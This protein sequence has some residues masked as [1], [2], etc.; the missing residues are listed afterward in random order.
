[1][2]IFAFAKQKVVTFLQKAQEG[3]MSFI[4]C[5]TCR[6]RIDISTLVIPNN[7]EIEFLGSITCIKH[8][9]QPKEHSFPIKFIAGKG[10]GNN[11]GI[12]PEPRTVNAL[13]AKVKSAGGKTVE[14][15]LK[16]DRMDLVQDITE[17]CKAKLWE[18]YK[19]SVVMCRRIVQ[20]PLAESLR[21]LKKDD[22]ETAIKKVNAKW[23]YGDLGHLT[24]GPLLAL[25]RNLESHLLSDYQH[26]QAK[27]IKDAGNDGAHNE[28]ELEPD[29]VDGN[30]REAAI[31]AASLVYQ[32]EMQASASQSEKDSNER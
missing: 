23:G 24:L 14:A 21:E 13:G 4:E 7:T 9:E 28:V 32:M 31:I 30:I 8:S 19:S 15:I 22:V 5:P 20:I 29:F 27:R 3:D 10:R 2:K 26:E 18:L 11:I 6:K 25:E 16:D 17:A 1:M 12:L